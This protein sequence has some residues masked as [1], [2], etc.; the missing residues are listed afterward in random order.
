MDRLADR[1]FKF[2]AAEKKKMQ[3][4]DT[5]RSLAEHLHKLI[6]K[7]P[8]S[9][10]SSLNAEGANNAMEASKRLR[11][12]AGGPAASTVPLAAHTMSAIPQ[13]ESECSV[14]VAPCACEDMVDVD[15][16]VD[17]APMSV[18]STSSTSST[19]STSTASTASTTP[20]P[21]SEKASSQPTPT[22]SAQPELP[23]AD[24]VFH[25][26]A[27]ILTKT[28]VCVE[29]AL[30][31][32][33]YIKRLMHKSGTKLTNRNWR[34]LLSV[35]MLIA[36]KVW[37]DLSMVNKDFAVFTPYSLKEINRWERL[38]CA[39]IGFDV[40]VTNQDYA[41]LMMDLVKPQR[42]M[43]ILPRFSLRRTRSETVCE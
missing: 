29:V 14:S 28:Q 32:V 6:V 26:L 13:S 20:A 9:S 3:A 22:T 7:V 18:S 8:S 31:A 39:G 42:Q 4:Q 34:S 23:S 30:V 35:S 33:L 11:P 12:G 16:S 15:V 37:D 2:W 36:G 38:F 27:L 19:A 24:A 43:R 21:P 5:L 25:W 10:S 40:S 17:G 1:S 41:N